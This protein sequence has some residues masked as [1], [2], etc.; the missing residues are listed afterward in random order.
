VVGLLLFR[1]ELIGGGDVKLLA[2]LS[3]W[4]GADQLVSFILVT[5]LTGGA[6]SVISLAYRRWGGLIAAQLAMLGFAAATARAAAIADPPTGGAP[7]RSTLPYGVAIA[8]GG[9]AVIV[10]LAKL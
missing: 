2:A 6:L 7:D 4:A 10:G 9:L 5:T 8:A 3:L 1:V